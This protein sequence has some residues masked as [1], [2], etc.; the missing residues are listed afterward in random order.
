[1]HFVLYKETFKKQTFQ[2]YF[3]QVNFVWLGVRNIMRQGIFFLS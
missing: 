1:M 3:Y 2:T